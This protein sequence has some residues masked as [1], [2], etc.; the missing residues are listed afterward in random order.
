MPFTTL[1]E[2]I[3]AAGNNNSELTEMNMS[4]KNVGDFYS[5]TIAEAITNNTHV[6]NLNLRH[7]QI[8]N[9]GAQKLAKAL[10][11]N[12]TL[13]V[14]SLSE[15]QIE[16]E[17]AKALADALAENQGLQQV[18]LSNNPI[19]Q[20]GIDALF[21]ALSK[22]PRIAFLMVDCNGT[23]TNIAT[24]SYR[25]AIE[26]RAHADNKQAAQPVPP[27]PPSHTLSEAAPLAIPRKTAPVIKKQESYTIPWPYQR[28]AGK[29]IISLLLGGVLGGTTGFFL[30]NALPIIGNIMG[31]LLG[32]LVGG[33]GGAFVEDFHPGTIKGSLLASLLGVAIAVPLFF[34][35]HINPLV[36]AASVVAFAAGGALLMNLVNYVSV[37]QKPA[38]DTKKKDYVS[39]TQQD[40]SKLRTTNFAIHHTSPL[41]SP[42]ALLAREQARTADLHQQATDTAR[43][44]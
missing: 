22:N 37:Y 23:P 28:T 19:T 3:E 41:S 7:N 42:R 27:A 16:N 6:L 25:E 13:N 15:N 5:I 20:E 8:K 44:G 4:N 18:F 35:L 30:G 24:A 17:G 9:K 38:D 10:K 31:L 39:V 34:V 26:K 32:A 1:T 29:S 14:L 43:P 12:R 21:K 2:M 33:F 40:D 36:L 11:I